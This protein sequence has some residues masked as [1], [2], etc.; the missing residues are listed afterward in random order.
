MSNAIARTPNMVRNHIYGFSAGGPVRKNKLFNFATFERWSTRDPK[1]HTS[2]MP[3]DLERVGDFSQSLNILGGL[4]VIHDPQTTV[5]NVAANR[6]PR[7]P[8]P[9]NKIPASMIDPVAKVYM[10]KYVWKPNNPGNDITGVQN[11]KTTFSWMNRYWNF[12]DRADWNISDKWKIFGR[13]S[14]F[15]T[16]LDMSK[17]VDSIAAN[18]S[19]GGQMNS[20]NVALD[21]VYTTSPTT[22][23]NLRWS[24]GSLQDDY[25]PTW[26]A[27]TR[28]GSYAAHFEHCVAVTAD[29]PW[30]LTRP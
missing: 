19:I 6:A 24:Y 10:T 30:V 20:R 2:T 8:F 17:F 4:R 21:T 11:F 29:G 14:R 23:L 1:N 7:Q 25:D 12:S 28:D 9:G 15:R 3:T 16:Q 22:V 18:N 26:T 5:L 27:V 13:Y